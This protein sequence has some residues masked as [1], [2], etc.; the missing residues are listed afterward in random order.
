MIKTK[1]REKLGK[2]SILS[3]TFADDSYVAK[4]IV[5]LVLTFSAPKPNFF[6]YM[7]VRLSLFKIFFLRE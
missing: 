4:V 6:I 3:F 2:L 5:F 1:L 7:R